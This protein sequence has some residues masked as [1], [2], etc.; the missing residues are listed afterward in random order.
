M[1]VFPSKH[2]A[3]GQKHDK[4]YNLWSEKKKNFLLIPIIE[5]KSL[6][7]IIWIWIHYNFKI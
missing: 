6:I 7:E 4:A 5:H 2:Y 3:T 1:I